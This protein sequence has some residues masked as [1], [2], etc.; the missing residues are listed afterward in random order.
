MTTLAA[1]RFHHV[2]LDADLLRAL[3]A[4]L[5]RRRRAAEAKAARRHLDGLPD[6]LLRDVGVTR[7]DLPTLDL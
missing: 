5:A 6:H 3:R 2:P 4:A 7:F 1:L